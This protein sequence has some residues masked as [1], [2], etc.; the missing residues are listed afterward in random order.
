MAV[1]WLTELFRWIAEGAVQR[2]LTG[3]GRL[4]DWAQE[5]L[6]EAMQAMADD[7]QAIFRHRDPKSPRA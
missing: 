1:E 6:R 3:P 2:A 4:P 5:Q 7:V